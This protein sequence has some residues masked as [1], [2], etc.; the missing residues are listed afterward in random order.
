SLGQNLRQNA[1]W[2]LGGA[3]REHRS[4]SLSAAFRNLDA[5][6]REDLI[7]RYDALCAHYLMEPSRNNRGVAHENGSLQ[8]RHAFHAHAADRRHRRDDRVEE[9]HA[10]QAR[11]EGS[12]AMI[13]LTASDL[14]KFH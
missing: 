5:D 4:D 7:S 9:A 12:T 1:L 8:S 11:T 10:A 6:A 2:S 13:D 3:P 14:T